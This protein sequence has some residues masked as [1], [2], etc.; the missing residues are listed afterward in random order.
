M[1]LFFNLWIFYVSGYIFA[2]PLRKWAD[3]KRG[4]PFEDSELASQKKAY[5]PAAIWIFGGFVISLFVP[6]TL[7]FLF[8]IGLVCAVLGLAIVGM[9]FYS[10]AQGPG[11]ATSKIHKYSRNPN[12]VGMDIF[13]GGL[14]LIGWSESFWS[15]VFLGYFIYTI[16][17]LHVAI[18]V[19][20]KF[21]ARKYGNSYKQYLARTP[22]YFGIRRSNSVRA[23][24][25]TMKIDRVLLA[26]LILVLII[27]LPMNPWGSV[28]TRDFSYMPFWMFWGYNAIILVVIIMNLYA[29]YQTAKRMRGAYYLSFTVSAAYLILYVLDLARIFPT[30]QSGAMPPLLELLE[31]VDSFVAIAIMAWCCRGARFVRTVKQK[32]ALIN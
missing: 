25:K 20:E 9:A 5:I 6:V 24:D 2:Y 1:F 13:I 31:I 4:E 14:V 10:F 15:I 12:Y 23:K 22:R 29:I 21:L 7:G 17:F 26:L 32:P 18:L 28:D 19:E 8:F 3:K 11:L 30:V 27:L 16:C